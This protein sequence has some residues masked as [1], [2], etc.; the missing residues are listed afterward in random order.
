[1]KIKQKK[2]GILFNF[3][4]K[5]MGGVIYIINIV[6]TLN[7]L[8]DDEKPEILLFHS[9]DLNKFLI[10]FNY[11]YI[12]YVEWSFPSI[13][14]GNLISVLLRKNLFID[15][16]IDDYSLDAIF[17]IH[18]FPVR[19]AT[20]V[21]LV[22]WWA[23]LQEKYYPK[24]FSPIQRWSRKVRVQHILK[25]CDHLVLSSHA[26]LED[27]ARFYHLRENLKVRI[28]HFVSVIDTIESIDI[29]DLRAKYKLPEKYFMVSNQFH[30]HKNHKVVLL[31]LAKLKETGI[32]PHIA[33]TGKFPSASDSPYLSELHKIIKENNLEEQV[34]M[35]GI[36]SRGEQLQ[37]MKYSQAVIQPSLF[38][39]WSTVIEDAKSLQVPVVASNLKVNIEQ[40]GTNCQFFNPLKPH[41]LVNIL[42]N[43]PER[44]MNAIFYE[45]YSERIIKAA[46]ELKNI[47]IDQD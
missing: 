3:S 36:I 13:I 12:Q 4:A 39:G 7:H 28:F 1:M 15:K 16:I 10:E 6:N 20:N 47:L 24:F 14:N 44:N 26:V 32:I 9:P 46:K 27:F 30:K 33:F 40:L 2:V 41:E 19:T 34:T 17:P 11:P 35:L 29:K 23:D 8:D 42:K 38:E 5:W 25:N 45:N 43:Y 18:D 37:L 21:K 22:A 31:A